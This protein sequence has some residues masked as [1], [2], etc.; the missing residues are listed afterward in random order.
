MH[1]D[2]SPGLDG[3]NPG[4]F[5]AYWG[6]IG[7]DV[8]R[9]CQQF[10]SKRDLPTGINRTVVCLIPNTKQPQTMNDLR[11]ISLR[12][13]LFIILSKVLTNRLMKCL[14]TIISEQQS[15]FVKCRLL[16]DNA[17]IAFEINH[18]IKRHT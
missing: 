7:E 17:L 14:P 10:I 15:A 6:I 11:P 1:P 5:Q 13:V 8:V 9:F 16:T 12:N 18:Y 4:F 3:L 2:K